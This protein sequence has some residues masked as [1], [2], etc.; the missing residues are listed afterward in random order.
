MRILQVIS[1]EKWTGIAAVVLDWTRALQ[2]AG[3]EA[4]FA[5]V[6]ES[7]LARRILP[8]GWARPVLTT[9]RSPWAF[10]RDARELR[11]LL[12]RERFDVVHT[13]RSH[14]HALALL[15]TRGNGARLARTVHHVAHLRRDPI[16]RLVFR[17]THAFSFA[18]REIAERARRP[19]AVHSP[20]VDADRFRP[21]EKPAQILQR[22]G[23]T[24]SDFVVGTVGKIA[25]GRG[26]AEAMDAAAPLGSGAV[27]LHV[28]KGE[29]MQALRA[30]MAE[31]RGVWAGYQEEDLPLHYRAMDVF[32]FTASGSQQGQRAILEAMASGLPTVALPV[33][34]VRDLLT[35][36]VEGFVTAD[37]SAA[38]NALRRI[39]A[40]PQLRA[41]LGE[42]AR[43]RA[44]AFGGAAF[45]SSAREFYDRVRGA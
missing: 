37:V 33:P 18:N 5:F 9:V 11:R 36:G 19:G 26:H 1:A 12:A 43:R 30:R 27:L 31:V 24:P 23:L 6:A 21:G 13:H 22:H 41:R 42:A 45:A 2:E 3:V 34:G 40:D 10:P 15:A 16:S 4:Q 14:D 8:A 44:L 38:T 20:V 39:A 29:S 35:D 32:L 25:P 28:G 7:P 17:R